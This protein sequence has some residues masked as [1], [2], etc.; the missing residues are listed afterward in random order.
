MKAYPFGN[1]DISTQRANNYGDMKEK[2]T[3]RIGRGHCFFHP[4]IP[5]LMSS[6]KVR[7]L[8]KIID[9]YCTWHLGEW[10]SFL[11]SHHLQVSASAT[12]SESHSIT[13]S[14]RQ[15]LWGVK[16]DVS[17]GSQVMS[18]TL[19]LQMIP[20]VLHIVVLHFIMTYQ[21]FYEPSGS[22]DVALW[23]GKETNN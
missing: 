15:H 4:L 5:R 14:G 9:L 1:Q 18:T 10:L 7:H 16:C 22:G 11:A 8:L 17:S 21:T 6:I 3:N 20:L 12:P 23:L 19:L 2:F 13:L